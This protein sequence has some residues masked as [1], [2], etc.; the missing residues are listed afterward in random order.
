[1]KKTMLITLL[2]FAF[3][4]CDSSLQLNEAN[5]EKELTLQE[6]YPKRTYVGEHNYYVMKYSDTDNF[7]QTAEGLTYV[8]RLFPQYHI[9]NADEWPR[10]DIEDPSSY[11]LPRFQFAWSTDDNR[12]NLR[13]WSMKTDGTDL[14]LVVPE[15]DVDGIELIRR[16]PNLRYVS[17]VDR[18]SSKY[19]YDLKTQQQTRLP[20]GARPGMVWSSD[21]RYLYFQTS[22]V[23]SN[24]TSAR[25]DSE[26]GEITESNFGVAF[27]A[28]L[29]GDNLTSVGAT[30]LYKRNIKTLETKKIS[31]KPGQEIMRY[32]RLKFRS[33]SPGGRF[34]WGTNMEADYYFDV[35]KETVEE[36]KDKNFRRPLVFGKDAKFSA[37]ARLSPLYVA[38]REKQLN[39][40]WRPL[41]NG[42][43]GLNSNLSL[44]NASANNGLWFKD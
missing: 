14:R 3:Y 15:S 28:V 17:W 41:G 44:Y 42:S 40:R 16:S 8:S 32:E 43:T 21:S 35:E 19:V 30:G 10:E 1:M 24:S 6:Q 39:W 26:T 34:A 27:G 12:Y 2:S 38:D 31:M 9:Q 20:G 22:K 33:V 25:W 23:S 37:G 11:D 13:I 29:N 5:D 7:K 4:G 36:I 18:A